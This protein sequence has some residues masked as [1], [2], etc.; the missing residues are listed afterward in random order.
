MITL[1][2]AMHRAV[3]EAQRAGH[4]WLDSAGLARWKTEYQA[5]LFERWKVNPPD[6]P[7]EGSVKRGRC[8]QSAA[9]NLLY[10]LDHHQ[11]VVLL[12][13][14]IPWDNSQAEPDIRMLNMQ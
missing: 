7:Q 2:N 4:A 12:F 1:L 6:P 5:L 14:E 10:R 11:E 8:K 3:K 13:L 9:R